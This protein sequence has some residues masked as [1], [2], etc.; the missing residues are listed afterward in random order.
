MYI[1]AIAVKLAGSSPHHQ[2]SRFTDGV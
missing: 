1:H 2:F